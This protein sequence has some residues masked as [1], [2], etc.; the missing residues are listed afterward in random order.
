MKIERKNTCRSV[1]HVAKDVDSSIGV[2]TV[3]VVLRIVTAVVNSPYCIEPITKA[4]T[5]RMV[6]HS[7]ARSL[8]VVARVNVIGVIVNQANN[9]TAAI[10]NPIQWGTKKTIV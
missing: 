9:K 1:C 6:P 10:T 5:M 8:A 4:S 2:S 3:R 7:A